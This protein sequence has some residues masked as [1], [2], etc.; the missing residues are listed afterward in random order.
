MK[1]E[2]KFFNVQV[3]GKDVQVEI[4]TDRKKPHTYRIWVDNRHP[5]IS[6]VAKHLEEGLKQAKEKSMKIEINEYLE[7]MYVFI[8]LPIPYHS[9]Q[10]S[11][12]AY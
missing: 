6:A 2:V 12:Q 7:R 11:A 9:N 5:D 10:Y 4:Q 3:V 1:R 8:V